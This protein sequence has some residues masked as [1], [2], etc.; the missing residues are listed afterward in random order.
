MLRP[1]NLVGVVEAVGVD[2]LVGVLDLVDAVGVVDLVNVVDLVD[3]VDVVDF[4]DLVDAAVF[5]TDVVIVEKWEE[6]VSIGLECA[7]TS[8]CADTMC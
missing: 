2:D 7:D 4:V 3:L 6:V 8:Q 5:P 1:R